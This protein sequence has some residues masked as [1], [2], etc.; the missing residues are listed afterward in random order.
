M[1]AA[2]LIA[3]VERLQLHTALFSRRMFTSIIASDMD[4]AET[5]RRSLAGQAKQAAHEARKLLR[6][7]G[8]LGP[9]DE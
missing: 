6:F 5:N 7:T 4:G 8:Q 3:C 1:T 2:E 9:E